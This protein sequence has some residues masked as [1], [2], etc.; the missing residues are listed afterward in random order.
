[1]DIFSSAKL[2][3]VVIE[4]YKTPE[5]G[6][7]NDDVEKNGGECVR[8]TCM[9]NP[10]SYKMT[11][12]NNYDDRTGIG[13]KGSEGGYKNTKS[14]TLSFKIVI[15]GTGV[16]DAYS[17]ENAYAVT[18]D[19]SDRVSDNIQLFR[20]EIMAYDGEIHQ[21]RYLRVIWGNLNFPCLLNTATINY[22]QFA[23][24]GKP[25]RADID[26]E[27]FY[28][29]PY[30]ILE[31]EVVKSSPD[32]THIRVVN[33]HDR[34]PLMCEKIYGAPGYYLW[35]AQVNQL[36]DFRNLTPGQEIYFPPIEK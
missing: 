31:A 28:D 13:D 36:D 10:E 4:A 19:V 16:D 15:D 27:F 30:E 32:L 1:M 24:N 11:T 6:G 23:S 35:V 18:R 25:L 14:E 20:S 33:A 8:Y 21:P 17:F 22:T 9:F 34:L 26:V 12:H 7:K 29:R 2:E 5:R 3:K